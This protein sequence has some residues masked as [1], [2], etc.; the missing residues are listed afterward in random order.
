MKLAS[1]NCRGFG[2]RIKEEALKDLIR[3]SNPEI[4]LIQETNMEEQDFLQA[5]KSF[6]RKG[7][8]IAV[9]ARG[10]SGGL[11][12]FWETSKYDLISSEACM[13]WVFTS[14]LHKEMGRLVSL[15]N[16]YVPVLFSEKR[17]CWDLVKA[18]L[19]SNKMENIIIGGDL[20]VTL[21]V[22]EKKGGSI[23]RDPAREWVEDIMLDWDL[24]DIKP[25]RE[26]FTWT[27]KR[28]G[29]GHIVARLDRFL[30][31]SSFLLLDLIFSSKILPHSVS[32]HKPIL[33]ELMQDRNLG[34]IPFRLSPAWIQYE[35]F[36]DLVAKVWNEKV[37]GSSFF[38]WEE[39][40]RKLKKVLKDWAKT[41][42]IPTIKRQEAQKN[43]EDHQLEMEGK[44][45]TQESLAKE[46]HLQ[47]TMHQAC[48]E[49]EGYW[50]QKSR[51]L[52][53][54][55]G[56]KNTNY[57]HKQAEARKQFKA[58]KEIHD[59]DQVITDFEGI[60]NASFETFKDLYTE[61]QSTF[62][63]TNTYP[64]SLVPSSIHEATNVNI[65]AQVKMQEIKEALDQMNPD[66]ASGPDGFTARFYQ[67]CWEIIK[68]DLLKMVLKSQRCS[69]IG[70]G[71]N[72]S[73]LA[74]I[75]KEKGVV[76]FGRFRPISLCNTGYKLITK[77]IANKLKKILPTIIPENQGGFI[78]GRKIVDNIT[79]VQEA[80]H[81]RNQRKYKGMIIKLDLANA[82]DRVRHNFLFK[83]MEN[84]GFSPA[85]INWI[86][87]C[88]RFPW[89][90][91]LVNGRATKLFQAS[92]GLRQGC[93][94]SPLL[95][96]IQAS[97]LSFQ[98]DYGQQ[99][100]NLLGL[101][102]DPG[103]KDINHAQFVDDTLLLGGASVQ[104]TRK[105]KTELDIYNEISG[106]EIILSKSKIYGWYTSPR[107]MLEISRVL[108]MEGFTNWDSFK[109]LGVPIFRTKPKAS[110]WL[111]LID[112]LKGRINS[113]GEKWL[114]LVGKV[115]L[116]KAV[117]ASIPI[118]QSSL[119]LAPT[120]MI[121]KIDA[122]FRRFL[123][124]GGKK[125]GR[126]L[127]LISWGKVTKPISEGGLHL[128][129]INFQ[130]LA[131]R[132]KLLW[133]LVTGKS[134]WR[135]KSIWKKYFH[136]QRT[137]CL[138]RPA[139]TVKG[140]PIFTLCLKAMRL[141]KPN[142]TWIPGNG[143]NINIWDD[144]VLGDPPLSSIEG[145]LI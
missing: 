93:P 48:K 110:Q 51:N 112:K 79:L 127:H 68:S 76:S 6:W 114:N 113:W 142:L 38:V 81:S 100:N 115:V 49:E 60:K 69:K 94:L 31:Q 140:S 37:Y 125:N 122:L 33:L 118:Y 130:N 28:V 17:N 74:L 136:G 104:T 120:T 64:L 88:I 95:Y 61:T 82:F 107:E 43:L 135:K 26:N 83:V 59:Q 67:N 13:H 55:A 10:A 129:D 84:F 92:R 47:R 1:W 16:L 19:N 4:L 62:P 132:A 20:N 42:K 50:Q 23:V 32:D 97:V 144:S 96:A 29:L 44:E 66:K 124:E 139:N 71:T 63:D 145:K 77:I 27:N 2:S 30:V 117:L 21:V 138:D 108:G 109:Y 119:L 12:T 99:H 65:L 25:S 134:T 126:K 131:L 128:R 5:S 101:R 141:F 53:L 137:K 46:D 90:A 57:F 14:L 9:S 91:P 121:Q 80:L 52:W 85:F 11:G 133:N 8:G 15:F 24:E 41:Q 22:E 86:K 18:F 45:I 70:G 75:P 123:W 116:I 98:L 106:S 58:V 40:L 34:P 3:M 103:V 39:N 35:G 7:Q 105:F 54:E 72:S 56:D 73:F 89:I 111:P 78:K 143:K 87:S 102:I 36:H